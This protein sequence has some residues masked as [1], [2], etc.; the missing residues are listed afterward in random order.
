MSSVQ[1]PHPLYK[2]KEGSQVPGNDPL[3]CRQGVATKELLL[4]VVVTMLSMLIKALPPECLLE[5]VFGPCSPME[6]Y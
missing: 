2:L 4:T 1:V 6:L 3:L 5:T